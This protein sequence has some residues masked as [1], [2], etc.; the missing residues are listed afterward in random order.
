M[1]AVGQRIHGILRA[2]TL[3]HN[4]SHSH[5]THPYPHSRQRTDGLSAV[6]ASAIVPTPCR[7]NP[8]T[9][10]HARNVGAYAHHSTNAAAQCHTRLQCNSYAQLVSSTHTAF[11]HVTSTR[12]RARAQHDGMRAYRTQT[13]SACASATALTCSRSRSQSPVVVHR[14]L[15]EHGVADAAS[16]LEPTDE[17]EWTHLQQNLDA[18]DVVHVE[19]SPAK[20]LR[21]HWG[22]LNLRLR[23]FVSATMDAVSKQWRWIAPP[24]RG[25]GCAGPPS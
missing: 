3:N 9:L 4:H 5:S 2:T 19:A 18:H 8:P 10:R 17:S 20:L 16:S 6:P 25:G 11:E 24:L 12:R 15:L 14:A 21:R 1:L 23:K 13:T 22:A 7:P